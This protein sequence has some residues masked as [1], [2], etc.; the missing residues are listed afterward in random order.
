MPLERH[1]GA[2]DSRTVPFPDPRASV[3]STEGFTDTIRSYDRVRISI[4]A[5]ALGLG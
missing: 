1:G 2:H 3:K 4:A 5:M